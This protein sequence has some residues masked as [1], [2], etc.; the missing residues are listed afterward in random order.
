M[1]MMRLVGSN[2][3]CVRGGRQ[4][5]RNLS[6][7]LGAGEALVVRGPN[8]VGKSSLLR[9]IAG[10][11]RVAT[12]RLDLPGGDPALEIAEQSHY[13]GH[14]DALKSALSVTENLAFWSSYLGAGG[15]AVSDA[16]AAVGLATL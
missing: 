13:L 4:V 5:F 11:I 7:A 1:V 6:F 8:G 15:I 16:L 2:L 14:Q 9:L 12:G 10:L 3:A